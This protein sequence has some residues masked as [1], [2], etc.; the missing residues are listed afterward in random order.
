MIEL[1]DIEEDVSYRRLMCMAHSLQLVIKKAIRYDNLLVKVH[2]IVSRIRKSSMAVE[3]LERKTGKVLSD[4]STR[5]HSTYR[6]S[7]RITEIRDAVNEVMTEQKLTHCSS[8]NGQ[9]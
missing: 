8:V 3:K 1:A 9:G 2:R 4:N 5:W 7:E 6:M